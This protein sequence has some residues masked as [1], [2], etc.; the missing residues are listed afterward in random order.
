MDKE[1]F[2]FFH[3]RDKVS[4]CARSNM[5]NGVSLVD[6]N[7]ISLPETL[8]V[9]GLNPEENRALFAE[10]LG[11]VQVSTPAAMVGSFTYSIPYKFS[12]AWA[13][14]TGL[15]D[16][17]LPAIDFSRLTH[18]E[19]DQSKLFGVEF[20]RIEPEYL[21]VVGKVAGVDPREVASVIGP[22]K[23]SFVVKGTEF[24]IF[25]K[26]LR[27][28]M[29]YLCREVPVEEIPAR[30][31]RF[32]KEYLKDGSERRVKIDNY[33]LRY[34][35]VLERLVAYFWGARVPSNN[36]ISLGPYLEQRYQ[37]AAS[38][39]DLLGTGVFTDDTVVMVFADSAY[40]DVLDRWL[41]SFSSVTSRSLLIVA[42]DEKL[43]RRQK[44]RGY[45]VALAAC[46]NAFGAKME[47]R[48]SVIRSVLEHGF[49]VVH[50]DVDAYWRADPVDEYI[51]AVDADIVAS[52]GTIWPPEALHEW[53]FV[54][55]S[56][57]AAY[58]ST[59]N[60]IELLGR[61]E[62]LTREFGSDQ[63]AFNV[64]LQ[65]DGLKWQK[66]ARGNYQLAYKE[67]EFTCFPYTLM[68]VGRSVRVALMPHR[69]I[70][71]LPEPS[72]SLQPY[73]VHWVTKKG[74]ASAKSDSLRDVRLVCSG[75]DGAAA[76][77]LVWLASYPRSGNT[78]LRIILWNNF[79]IPSYSVYNDEYDIADDQGMAQVC[80]HRPMDFGRFSRKPMM[81]DA[82]C[83][84]EF[85]WLRGET[86]DLQAVKTHSEWHTGFSQDRVIYVYRD[87]RSAMRSFA[88][89]RRSF[90]RHE[91]PLNS[92]L[93]DLL[94]RA[95]EM[96]GTWSNNVR[97]W[98]EHSSERA[99]WLRF[100]DMVERPVEMIHCIE[101]F[102]GRKANNMDIVGFSALNGLNN[103]FF[104]A[105]RTSSWHEVF[106]DA[107]HALFWLINHN[108]MRRCGYASDV[109]PI[110]EFAGRSSKT[111]RPSENG[112]TENDD[113]DRVIRR[114]ALR[115]M[116]CPE[117]IRKM[118]PVVLG[119]IENAFAEYE[120]RAA[121]RKRPSQGAS[122]FRRHLEWQVRWGAGPI[123]LR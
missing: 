117:V 39:A 105:G 46:E 69:V 73:V 67:R 50:S 57:F 29:E 71:R 111:L 8:I 44:S 119:S 36:M 7:E 93:D 121:F 55:C 72:S 109:S 113:V 104:R 62:V 120:K 16:L 123:E 54:L 60:V 10:Y 96:C 58:R 47:H 92:V 74:D 33:R 75:E 45:H 68:G 19:Y 38:V 89:Y 115:L 41:E 51:H 118:E 14:K 98:R 6:L 63:R 110:M 5:E 2:V 22:F 78:M 42:M 13:A 56:G 114:L 40:Q 112:E 83:Y 84:D 49:N 15:R 18:A 90:A 106:D 25:Q 81:L 20:K 86:N 23:G 108:E 70:Q 95:P 66:G 102:L 26:W 12:E 94:A 79:G 11:M 61:V 82:S 99:L 34:G 48:T 101:S 17:F 100:E 43:Y 107:Q 87:G 80:G 1:L 9:D 116:R 31:S 24:R 21:D 97:S 103:R 91:A 35:N 53:G 88:S 32:G 52:Q 85:D 3:D 27:R 65:E 76:S 28:R 122:A 59:T 37:K 30:T 77:S 4:D 64:V